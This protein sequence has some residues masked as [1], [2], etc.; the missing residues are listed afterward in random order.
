MENTREVK[1]VRL[2]LEIRGE[3]LEFKGGGTKG[4]E[5]CSESSLSGGG[6]K[7][8]RGGKESNKRGGK[9]EMNWE[10]EGQGQ[11][12]GGGVDVCVRKRVRN[13]QNEAKFSATRSGWPI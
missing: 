10:E 5:E 12:C 8:C 6:R 1:R 4:K 2:E 13:P 3:K 7:R 9:T 11:E